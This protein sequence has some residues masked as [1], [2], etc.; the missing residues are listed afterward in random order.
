MLKVPCE[1]EKGENDGEQGII[2]VENDEEGQETNS[3]SD[4]SREER[5]RHRIQEAKLREEYMQTKHAER[6]YRRKLIKMQKR[7]QDELKCLH[8]PT[9]AVSRSSDSPGSLP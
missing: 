8:F 9:L 2:S 5:L 6:L 7:V 4:L 1:K 3:E